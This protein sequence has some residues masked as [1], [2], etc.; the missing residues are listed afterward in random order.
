[1]F[2]STEASAQPQPRPS[3]TSVRRGPIAGLV[4]DVFRSAGVELDGGLP[5]EPRI[6]KARFFAR[7]LAKG[8]LGLGES[9]VDGDW[10]CDELDE[11]ASRLL[12]AGLSR[13]MP[14]NPVKVVHTGE[15]ILRNVQRAS[16]ARRDVQKHYDRDNA[17]YQAMLDKRLTYSCGYWREAT[18]L[19]E[20]Q[21]AKLELVCRKLGLRRGQTVLDIGCG[22][23]SF[24]RYAAERY[25]AHVYGITLSPKQAE[26]GR[27]LARGL[28]VELQVLDYR[29]LKGTFDRVVSIGMLEHVGVK[30]YRTF[31]E[32]AHRCLAPDGLMLLHTIGARESTVS[33][34]P[35]LDRYIFP[36]AQLPS[37]AQINRALE[38]LFVVEDLHNFGADY[39][40]TLMAW[41][42]NFDRNWPSLRGRYDERFRRMWR[43][44]LS[45]CAGSF[46]SRT[47]Q[48][49]QLVLSKEGV[50][51]GYLSIR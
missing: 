25:G 35:W 37:L 40:R 26:L 43:Y 7:V 46:R 33:F 2:E 22:W 5:H 12:R 1:M 49:Y 47:N 48:L 18:G 30:N 28:P 51:G 4:A 39:D 38:G 41:R 8:S 34:D 36:G 15:R 13:R 27:E 9:Y 31:F 50:P 21:E 11:L 32:V 45:V 17:L 6:H 24:A 44:Y 23:G 42:D 29:E 14:L 16:R 10:D 19:D 20:A 3:T